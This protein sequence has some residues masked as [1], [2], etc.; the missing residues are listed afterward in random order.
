MNTSRMQVPLK[1][2]AGITLIVVITTVGSI[3]NIIYT[4]IPPAHTHGGILPTTLS[5][6]LI[7]IDL[8]LAYGLWMLKKW[9]FWGTVVYEVVV[10][11]YN[12]VGIA[13]STSVLSHIVALVFPVLIL[14]YLLVNRAVRA[15]FH[16]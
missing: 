5:L 1:R 4:L 6:L 16:I 2:P 3:L 10:I 15:A 8:V 7:G 12:I 13:S 9:A 14:I 11:A